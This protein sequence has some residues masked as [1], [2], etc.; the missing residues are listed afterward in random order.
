MSKTTITA[1]PNKQEL[2]ITREFNAPRELV[3]KA[4]TTPETLLQFYAPFGIKMK[5]NY[6]NF[7]NSG[8]YS[9]THFDGADK[10]YCTFKGVIHEIVAPERMIQTVEMENQPKG[11]QVC[12]EIFTFEE[13]SNSK[14]K[15]IVQN[16]FRSIE[17]RDEMVQSGFESGVVAIFEQL[18]TL[19]KEN[20]I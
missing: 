1:E 3:F 17:D 12:L 6:A 4:F 16:V 19:I 18:D 20:K 15:L 8:S 11:G 10:I 14:T 13:L 2:F 7:Q 5:F 9:W